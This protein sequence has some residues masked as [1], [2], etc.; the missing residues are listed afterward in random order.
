MQR[1][2]P[3]KPA[4][5]A[6]NLGARAAMSWQYLLGSDLA[7]RDAGEERHSPQDYI[8]DDAATP[9]QTHQV[10]NS[11]IFPA[12]RMCRQGASAVCYG[13]GAFRPQPFCHVPVASPAG[14]GQSRLQAFLR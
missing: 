1:C 6:K 5:G 11:K 9:A 4:E 14:S 13:D 2:D 3:H 8:Q 10:G 7:G 12:I